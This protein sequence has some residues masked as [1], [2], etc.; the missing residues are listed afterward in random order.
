M[1][2]NSRLEKLLIEYCESKIKHFDIENVEG[3]SWNE[4]L[5]EAELKHKSNIAYDETLKNIQFKAQN[6]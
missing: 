6:Q 4:K 3:I 5:S 1:H 2:K